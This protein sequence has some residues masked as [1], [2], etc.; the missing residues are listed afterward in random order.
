[1]S[2]A[3]TAYL[4]FVPHCEQAH[5]KSAYCDINRGDRQQWVVSISHPSV[6]DLKSFNVLI[7]DTPKHV[8]RKSCTDSP[9]VPQVNNNDLGPLF[10]N[11]FDF[12]FD[13]NDDLSFPLCN[14]DF[15]YIGG[16]DASNASSNLQLVHFAESLCNT[17]PY[18]ATN[19]ARAIHSQDLLSLIQTPTL[20][21]SSDLAYDSSFTPQE[22]AYILSGIGAASVPSNSSNGQCSVS[23]ASI[24]PLDWFETDEAQLFPMVS[25]QPTSVVGSF[26]LPFYLPQEQA[27]SSSV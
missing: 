26:E 19:V 17:Q 7:G 20:V 21:H 3:P 2:C 4:H 5:A 13:Y 16:F 1:M 22:T 10:N 14:N 6:Y 11:S 27:M 9:D 24:K 8:C 25:M 18:A 12:D 15:N 23:Y